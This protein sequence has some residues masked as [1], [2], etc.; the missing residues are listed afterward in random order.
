[1][2]GSESFAKIYTTPELCFGKECLFSM[3]EIS[4]FY[5]CVDLLFLACQNGKTSTT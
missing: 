1:M 4:V 2:S 3:L 5:K